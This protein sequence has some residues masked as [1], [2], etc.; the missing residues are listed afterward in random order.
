[1]PQFT[2][3]HALSLLS[4]LLFTQGCAATG[5]VKSDDTFHTQQSAREA[6]QQLA[7]WIPTATVLDA[8]TKTLQSRGFTCRAIQPVA[9][10][11]SSTLCTLG[12]LAEVPPTQR[13]AT[14]VTPI[15]WFVM[16]N[17]VDGNAV[18]KVL[19]NRAPKDIGD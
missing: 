19:V 9:E 6:R 13:L 11:R 8:A 16:L 1:M 17:S 10:L 5:A 15:H 14:S 7:G 18:S 4:L 2:R 12:P 3:F